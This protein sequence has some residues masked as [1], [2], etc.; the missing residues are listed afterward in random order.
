MAAKRRSSVPDIKNVSSQESHDVVDGGL[1]SSDVI[2]TQD[3]SGY[4]IFDGTNPEP[5][6]VF[7]I[8]N[9]PDGEIENS[10]S[11]IE[12]IEFD[13]E[14][15]PEN[16]INLDYLDMTENIDPV[17]VKLD[18]AETYADLGDIAGA[19]EI[20]EEI[21]NESNKEG[22]RRARAVLEKLDSDPL[23]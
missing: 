17:D 20:L 9:T 6:D 19:R 21:I 4:E 14:L 22:K 5:E 10:F 2:P 11:N 23:S 16:S 8:E 1:V 15:D 3:S 13:A 7:A 12:S 18:L